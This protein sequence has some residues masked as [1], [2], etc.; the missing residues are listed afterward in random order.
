MSLLHACFELCDEMGLMISIAHV[1]HG[2]RPSSRADADFV[3]TTAERYGLKFF[4]K[5]ARPFTGTG[6][7]EA[8]GRNLRYSFFSELLKRECIDFVLTA[9]NADDVAETFLMRLLSNKEPRSIEERDLRRRCLRPFLSVPRSVIEAYLKDNELLHVEDPTND[10]LT[11]LRNR[12]RHKLIPMLSTEFDRRV[13]ETL[14]RRAVSIA[15]DIDFLESLTD[16]AY[17]SVSKEDFG[18][19]SW[20]NASNREMQSLAVPLRWRFA[21]RLVKD[22]LGFNLGKEKACELSEFFLA[23]TLQIELPMGFVLRRRSGGIVVNPD[24]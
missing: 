7:V 10:D 20:L 11:F 12:V 6:N 22:L 5:T 4:L 21:R 16:S 14:A 19:K 18:T 15:E 24:N 9:H 8:W 23:G 17:N 1:D 13:S 2:L 3:S